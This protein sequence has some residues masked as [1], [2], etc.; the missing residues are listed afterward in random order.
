MPW[1]P[2]QRLMGLL[3]LAHRNSYTFTKAILR[4]SLEEL[5]ERRL[6]RVWAVNAAAFFDV[7]PLHPLILMRDP[8]CACRMEDSGQSE[9]H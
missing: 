7:H 5:Q 2:D 4:V 1:A 6:S 9:R 3:E 8:G